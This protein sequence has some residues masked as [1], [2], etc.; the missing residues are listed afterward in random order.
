MSTTVYSQPAASGTGAEVR[1]NVLFAIERLKAKSPDPIPSSDLISFIYSS[2]IAL[3][4]PTRIEWFKSYLRVNEK[5]TYTPSTDSYSFRPIHNIF[6]SDD[7]LDFLQHQDSATG[8]S[9]RDL[10]DGWPGVEPTIT[11]LEKS[12]KL[13]VTRNKKD[14][15]PRMVWAD[16]PTLLTPMD[17]EYRT[18]WEGISVPEN[19]DD[20]VRALRAEGLNTAGNV[21]Q[22]RVKNEKKKAKKGPRRGQKTTNTHMQ[23][24]FKD[25]SNMNPKASK[26]Q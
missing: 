6:T 13:L 18:L 24:L 23:G 16:D 22:P 19:H 11:A 5:V 12:H 25:Y 10:K 15:A 9:V 3:Q 26:N 21:S 2:D 1:T 4:D 8:I 20:V 7:L 14:N 17:A